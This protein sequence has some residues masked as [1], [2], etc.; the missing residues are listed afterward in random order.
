MD[1][2][3][4]ERQLRAARSY[5]QWVAAI[6]AVFASHGLVFG[7][8][9]DNAGD[10]AF[11]LVRHLQQWDDAAWRRSP[12]VALIPGAVELVRRRVVE[13]APL[14]YLLHEAWFAGLC[15]YVDDRV[16]VPRSPLAE[17]IERG[18][19]PWCDVRPGDRVL[20]IGTGSGCLAIATAVHWPELTVDATDLSAAALAVARANAER[21]AVGNLRLVEADLFPAGSERYRVILS[22]PPYVPAGEV[23]ELPPEYR[24]EPAI[25][26]AGGANG[27][28]AVDRILRESA[29]RLA[30]E[31]VLFMEV[32]GGA[33]AFA[34]AYPE[35]PVVWLELERGGEGV[36]M[37]G[38]A[39]LGRAFR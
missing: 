2:A 26:L 9:T 34:S 3:A 22:N 36:F 11:W 23:A 5:E 7:H 27:F 33:A 25:A 29:A 15:F 17:V 35:L 28:A 4:L 30:S 8:G 38:A 37:I 6:A 14:A 13:R 31:G 16:L 24:H 18:F 32:G 39:E 12:D 21:H 10:E 20:D 1:S 19:A